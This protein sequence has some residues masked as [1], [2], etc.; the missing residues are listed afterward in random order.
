MSEDGR[1]RAPDDDAFAAGGTKSS[2]KRPSTVWLVVS[3]L[4]LVGVSAVAAFA[5]GGLPVSQPAGPSSTAPTSTVPPAASAPRPVVTETPSP[6]M[7]VV[8][9]S[10]SPNPFTPLPVA[11]QDPDAA[12]LPSDCSGLYSSSMF[13]YLS[14]DEGLPLNDGTT[15]EPPFSKTEKV[16]AVQAGLPG[17]VCTWAS[18]GHFGLLTQANEVTAAQSAAALTA[19]TTSGFYCHDQSGGTRCTVK[20]TGAGEAWGESHFLR[21]NVW[22]CTFWSNFTPTGYTA[23]MVATLWG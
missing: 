22:L 7:P 19:L 1:G 21:G 2:R 20:N 23:D 6:A 18:A 16:A 14:V 9:V 12:V 13:T 17:L 15:S 5:V 3:V 8:P 11:P 10:P 4:T